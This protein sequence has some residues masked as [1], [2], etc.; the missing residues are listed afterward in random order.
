MYIFMEGT[1]GRLFSRATDFVDFVDFGDFHEICF[2][3]N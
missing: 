1:I 2:T 3:K